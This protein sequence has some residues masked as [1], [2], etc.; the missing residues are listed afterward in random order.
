MNTPKYI[1]VAALK[2]VCF[3]GLAFAGNS[4][5]INRPSSAT[6]AT[7]PTI[8][9]STQPSAYNAS[10][11]IN[12]V[13][14][15]LP[16]APISNQNSL[17]SLPYTAVKKTTSYIDGLGRPIQSVSQQSSPGSNPVDLVQPVT[18]DQYGRESYKYLLFPS[19]TTDGDFK[20]NPFQEQSNFYIQQ[21]LDG[22]VVFYGKTEFDGSPTNRPSK[23]MAPGNSWAGS[24]RGIS[25]KYQINSLDGAVRIWNIGTGSPETSSI[26]AAGQLF[27]NVT[28]DEAN[29]AVVEYKDKSGN[30]ILK[31]VQLGVTIPTDYSGQ[32]EAWLCTYY[33]YDDLNRLVYVIP[34][35]AV[36]ALQETGINWNI[37]AVPNLEDE[38]CFQYKYD[39]RNRMIEKKVPGAAWVYMIY[40]SRDRL[41]FTQDGNMRARDQWLT[42]LYDVLNRPVMTGMVTYTGSRQDLTDHVNGLTTG[43]TPIVVDGPFLSNSYPTVITISTLESGVRNHRATE[44]I[45]FEPGF[46]TETNTDLTA[47]IIPP[48]PPANSESFTVSINPI[49]SNA[50]FVPLTITYYD[51]YAWTNNA[52]T[53]EHNA[54]LSSGNNLHSVSLPTQTEQASIGT[55]GMVTGTRVRTLVNPDNLS[56]GQ[57]LTNHLYYDKYGRVIQAKNQTLKGEDIS[58]NLYDFSGKLLCSYLVHKN[59]AIV[60]ANLQTTTVK[61]ELEYDHSGAILKSFKTINGGTRRLILENEYN[62]LG[63]LTVKKL[64]EVPGEDQLQKLTFDYNIRGWMKGINTG[65]ARGGGATDD[66]FGMELNYDWGFDHN[67]YNGNISGTKWRSMGDGEQRAYGFGY[68]KANRIMF[69][70]FNQ[71]TASTWNKTAGIDFSSYMGDGSIPSTAYDANGN[72]L[73]MKQMGLKLNVSDWV[74]KLSYTYASNGVSNKLQNVIDFENTPDTKLGDFRTSITSPNTTAKNAFVQGVSDPFQIVD[75]QY[76]V[77]GNLTQDLNKDIDANSDDGIAYN[78]LNLP[79]KITVKKDASNEK[80]YITYIYDATGNKLRKVVNEKDVTVSHNNANYTSDITTATDYI[81]GFIYETKTYAN[82]NLSSLAYSNKLQFLQH[83]EGRARPSIDESGN[84]TFVYDYFIKDH[85]GNVRMVLTEEE[86]SE[87]YLATMEP[88]AGNFETQLFQKVEETRENK[89]GGFDQLSANEKVSKLFGEGTSDKRVGPGKLL[90]VMAGDKFTAKVFGWY[91]P[92]ATDHTTDPGLSSIISS[93]ITALSGS[94]GGAGKSSPAEIEN[95]GVLTSPLQNL[96]QNQSDPGSNVP[97]AYLNYILL[98]EAQLK[99]VDGDAVAIPEI[100]VVMEKQLLQINNGNEVDITS[101]GY[102]YVYVSNESKGNVYFDDLMIEHIHGPLLEE[103]HYYPFGLTMAGI[104]SKAASSLTNKYKYNG[105]EEQR[106]E[107]SAGD[108][109]ETYDYALRMQ[110]PQIGKFWQIDPAVGSFP[111]WSPYNYAFNNPMN[112]IDPD[113]ATGVPVIDHEKKRI[114]ITSRLWVYGGAANRARASEIAAAIQQQWNDAGGTFTFTDADGNE[115]TYSIVFNVTGEY[116][117]EGT[118]NALREGGRL[119]DQDNFVRLEYGGDDKWNGNSGFLSWNQFKKDKTTAAH[120]Y[121]HGLDWKDVNQAIN[122]VTQGGQHDLVGNHGADGKRY[123]GI[124][125]PGKNMFL[126]DMQNATVANGKIG[127]VNPYYFDKE[128]NN[129]IIVTKRCATQRDI[130]IVLRNFSPGKTQRVGNKTPF[131]YNA[132]GGRVRKL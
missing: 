91:Q 105:K 99:Y 132:T 36:L 85:L 5:P 79:Y 42:T 67:Q 73:A 113:G 23:T 51:N 103:T 10:A 43:S 28:L 17:S 37:T 100:T 64:G 61:T 19:T 86:K 104:S 80:G 30:V 78:H 74:D 94:I 13:R 25:Q 124:M 111:S 18:Y 26:Y 102:L 34:P 58:T 21:N 14:T 118:I 129:A 44:V 77:N 66:R 125:T 15:W 50:T 2:T 24:G 81:G 92:G 71:Y 46:T 82:S 32:D 8:P 11:A 1:L 38:L 29:N 127:D 87:S 119:A 108:G 107:F 95:S 55:K 128:N 68:D 47:E 60:D 41:V 7:P 4:Q 120:E 53:T 6:I 96:L 49:P 117:S 97:K 56:L 33:V 65:Y 121:G 88:A 48:V 40:D 3:L 39:H 9:I 76:D 126:K 98:S 54:N 57:W 62:S 75:Y 22:E 131:L 109:L 16:V 83:E 93:L 27:K 130:Q 45:T 69:A 123:P 52:Y 20:S 72:I 63:Q 106:Q 12:Y 31:K 112:I 122:P 59:N 90:K 101:N 84:P 114:T 116:A 35:K 89:P 115:Q 110:D 70:D